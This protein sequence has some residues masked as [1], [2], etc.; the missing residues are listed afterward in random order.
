MKTGASQPDR[1]D[2][3]QA[4]LNALLAVHRSAAMRHEHTP[5]DPGVHDTKSKP[6]A[7][8]EGLSMQ[9]HWLAVG[10]KNERLMNPKWQTIV[11]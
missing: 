11:K 7:V 9:G 8:S 6:R 4:R 3:D 1:G 5:S 2:M 10:A